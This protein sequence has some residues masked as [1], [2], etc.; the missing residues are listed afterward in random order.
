MP[1]QFLGVTLRRWIEYLAAIL[2]GN[3]IYYF[4]LVPH[5]P[6][7]LKHQG[8]QIDLGVAVDFTVCVAVYGLIWIGSRL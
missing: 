6:T 2:I 8:F 3:A 7:L 1:R 4:S 5:L